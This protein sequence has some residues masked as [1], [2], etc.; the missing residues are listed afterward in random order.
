MALTTGVSCGVSC[1]RQWHVQTLDGR[2]RMENG[3]P[4]L[5]D[6][7]PMDWLLRACGA[8]ALINQTDVRVG[9]DMTEG[10]SFS[11]CIDCMLLQS[12]L[13]DL[14]SGES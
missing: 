8:R 5:E 2:K 7:V 12:H 3:V 6:T 14:P 4:A 11:K 9:L 10:R 1:N 13:V